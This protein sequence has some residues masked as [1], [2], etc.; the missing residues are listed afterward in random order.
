V[1]GSLSQ[2]GGASFR[3]EAGVAVTSFDRQ[4]GIVRGERALASDDPRDS[5]HAQLF[6]ALSRGLREGQLTVEEA[7]LRLSAQL[8]GATIPTAEAQVDVDR[9]RRCGFPEV[10]YSE[11]KTSEA[12]VAIMQTLAAAGESGFATRVSPQQAEALQLRFP[13]TIYNPVAR[14]VR[15]APKSQKPPVGYVVVVTAG[16]SDRPVAEEALETLHWME[17]GAELIVDIGVAGPKRL[18]QQKHRFDAADCVIVIAGMEGALPS[19]VGGWVACPVVA[20]PTSVGYGA[21]FGG[22]AALLGM[23]NSCA[24]NVC[25]VNIDSGFKGAY[26]AGMIARQSHR[27]SR[28]PETAD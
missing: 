3:I 2:D 20:V 11:G 16:T 21:S 25:V 23:L 15:L 18:L 1:R 14:T 19:V 22:I 27:R 17:C 26:I 28:R 10:I 24:S 5:T 13:S 7:V 12:V 8:D 4:P 9:M 6:A